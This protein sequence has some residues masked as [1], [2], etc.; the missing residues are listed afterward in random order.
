MGSR[1][2]VWGCA[3]Y[4]STRE[5]NRRGMELAK[6]V[7]AALLEKEMVRLCPAPNST[8]VDNRDR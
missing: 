6:R 7:I 3:D 5:L 8:A 2:L 4:G 1:E